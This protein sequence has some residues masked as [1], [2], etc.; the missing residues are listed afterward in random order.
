[1]NWNCTLSGQVAVSMLEE[2]VNLNLKYE[3]DSL[4]GS[5][6]SALSNKVKCGN[7]ECD[8]LESASKTCDDIQAT[9]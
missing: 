5:V 7:A 2:G 4:E 8:E 3:V 6:S 9:I 1:M